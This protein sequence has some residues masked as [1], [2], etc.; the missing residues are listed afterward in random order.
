MTTLYRWLGM[1]TLTAFERL[2]GML[3][4]ALSVQM[5]LDGVAAYLKASGVGS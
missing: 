2:M 4:V 5:L 3:L 1:R